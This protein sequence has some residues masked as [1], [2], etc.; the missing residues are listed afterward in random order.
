MLSTNPY[1]PMEKDKVSDS[2]DTCILCLSGMEALAVQRLGYKTEVHLQAMSILYEYITAKIV[3]GTAY[4]IIE[5][6][7]SDGSRRFW[8]CWEGSINSKHVL[9]NLPCCLDSM[10]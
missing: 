8:L 2:N 10:Q 6:L 7:V 9:L 4:S 3:N 1:A 5:H